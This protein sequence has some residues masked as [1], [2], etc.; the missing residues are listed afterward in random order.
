MKA[1]RPDF[2]EAMAIVAGF[3]PILPSE[4]ISISDAV[5]RVTAEP[6]KA[7]RF[8]PW[9]DLSAMDG[10]IVSDRDCIGETPRLLSV[11]ETLFAGEPTFPLAE[12]TTRAIMTGAA[13]PPGGASVLIKERAERHGPVLRLTENLPQ[14]MNIRRKGEDAALGEVVLAAGRA[15]SPS[16]LGA[17][18][19]YGVERLTVRCRPNIIVIPTGDELGTDGGIPDINGPMIRAHLEAMGA[20]V[21]LIEPVGDRCDAIANAIGRALV[22]ADMVVTT[23]GASAGERDHLPDAVRH[24]GATTHFHGVRM[25]PGKPV[26]FATAPNGRPL[27]CLPGNPVA[28]LVA[29]RFFVAHA[30]RRMLAMTPEI[31][32]SVLAASVPANDATN[33]SRVQVSNGAVEAPVDV[34]PGERSHMMRSLLVADHW[35]VQEPRAQKAMLYPLTDRL[36]CH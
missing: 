36:D 16:M 13:I 8:H 29:C 27:F 21:T 32:R 19:A 9:T 20:S 23:G 4:T 25:R 7:C 10:Y 30:I 17:L 22:T 11:E 26:L 28:A 31:G 34:I 1:D 24:I 18:I 35:M 14:G 12:G 5:G 3:V 6:L 2:S 15:V 33:I